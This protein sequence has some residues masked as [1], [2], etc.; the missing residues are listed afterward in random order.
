MKIQNRHSVNWG[1][2]MFLSEKFEFY[3]VCVV[4]EYSTESRGSAN[5]SELSTESSVR[6]SKEVS[7][8][9]NFDSAAGQ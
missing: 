1:T 8:N 3:G 6:F 9:N 7:K 5:L 2:V 4:E